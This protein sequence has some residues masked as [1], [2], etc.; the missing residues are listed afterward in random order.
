[1]AESFDIRQANGQGLLGRAPTLPQPISM[2]GV[3]TETPSPPQACL[4]F[5]DALDALWTFTPKPQSPA[6]DEPDP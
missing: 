3:T 5:G 1:M 2:T 6:T 4:V